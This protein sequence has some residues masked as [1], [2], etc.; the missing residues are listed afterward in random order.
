VPSGVFFMVRNIGN[1]VIIVLLTG[2]TQIGGIVY[3]ILLIWKRVDKKQ[4][5]AFRLPILFFAFYIFSTFAI[6]PYLSVIFNRKS[7]PISQATIRP[8]AFYTV[9]MNR[10]YVHEDLYRTM[11]EIGDQFRSKYPDA[12]LFY[13]DA[14]FPFINGF[15]L[16][17]HLSHDDGRKIDLAFVYEKDGSIVPNPS[18]TGYGIFVNEATEV[19]SGRFVYGLSRYL[20]WHR[21][22]YEGVFNKTA[23]AD[24]I[25]IMVGHDR[26]EKIF[27]EP[28][29]KRNLGIS[30][31]KVR[32]QGC[33]SVRHDDHIHLQIR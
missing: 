28:Y 32:F 30:H 19:C 22:F 16:W 6:I 31:A 3:L 25:E 1:I 15:P 23:T 10:H 14:G 33:H 13:L 26:V 2:L 20:G 4:W 24:L 29:L 5:P 27:L 11:F 18:A 12:K 9:L 8:K 7:L 17:P 21:P